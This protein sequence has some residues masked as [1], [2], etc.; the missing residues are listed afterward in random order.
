[1]PLNKRLLVGGESVW[2]PGGGPHGLWLHL[3]LLMLHSLWVVEVL[4]WG[5]ATARSAASGQH[6]C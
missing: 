3:R 4:A 6:L 5:H 1:M 2:D